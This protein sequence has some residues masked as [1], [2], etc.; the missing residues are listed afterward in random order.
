MDK[1]PVKNVIRDT[2]R[3]IKYIIL[4]DKKLDRKQMLR[5]IRY[6]NM[7]P[8]N[9]KQKGGTTVTIKANDFA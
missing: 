6:F 2:R 8:L 4:A 9:I 3:N 7:N 5:Q 1:E